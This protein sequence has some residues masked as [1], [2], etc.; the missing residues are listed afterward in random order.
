MNTLIPAP[1]A[2]QEAEK[3]RDAEEGL[4]ASEPD[5]RTFL[6]GVIRA[7]TDRRPASDDLRMT[8]RELE[9]ALL[10]SAERERQRISQE[11]HHHLCQHLLG[12]AFAAKAL[13]NNLDPTSPAGAEADE[14]AR[15]IN[16]TVQ[17][18][19][20]IVCGLNIG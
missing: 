17:Q 5:F 6:E 18:T 20:D 9:R 14:L 11:L 4:R 1:Y 2:R 12:A 8:R 13:A 15:L 3:R 16:S 10:H 19:R 7:I